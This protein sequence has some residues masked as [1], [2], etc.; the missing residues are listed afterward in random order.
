MSPPKVPT[1]LVGLAKIA[2]EFFRD[3][4]RLLR[5]CSKPDRAEFK[6]VSTRVGVWAF[7]AGSVAFLIK[8]IFLPIRTAVLAYK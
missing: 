5:R 8:I 1:R 3:S 7:I 6:R 2:Q 4:T